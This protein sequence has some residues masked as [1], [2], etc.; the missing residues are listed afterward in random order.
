M[1]DNL[2]AECPKCGKKTVVQR[3]DNLYQCLNCDFT[4]DFATPPSKV[5][6]GFF[7]AS[8]ITTFLALLLLPP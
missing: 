2:N 7:W 8:L 4:R 3:Q 5:N 1:S 6:N